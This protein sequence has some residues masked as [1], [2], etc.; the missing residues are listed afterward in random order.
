[1]FMRLK[2]VFSTHQELHLFEIIL[3]MFIILI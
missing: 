3:K 2:E 1:M